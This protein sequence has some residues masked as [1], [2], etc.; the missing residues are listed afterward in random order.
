MAQGSRRLKTALDD[1]L[2]RRRIDASLPRARRPVRGYV[3]AQVIAEAL[4][5]SEEYV[6]R[7]WRDYP[8]ARRLSPRVI[9]FDPVAF[10]AYLDQQGRQ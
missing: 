3:T 10:D 1:V 2:A 8:F 9:R 7:H 4:G 5:I 6:K